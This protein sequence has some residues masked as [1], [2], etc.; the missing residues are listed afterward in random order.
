MRV[1]GRVVRTKGPAREIRSEE[2]GL[3]SEQLV[4]N[5]EFSSRIHAQTTYQI[6]H[7]PPPPPQPLPRPRTPDH[8]S[9]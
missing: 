6:P 4:R 2:W 8:A 3:R 7:S 1:E 9:G 5:E